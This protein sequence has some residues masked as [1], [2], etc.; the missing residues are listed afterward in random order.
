MIGTTVPTVIASGDTQYNRQ[1][2]Q[3]LQ[4][5]VLQFREFREIT[6]FDE[7]GALIASSRVG[8]PRITIPKDTSM[9]IDGV[10]MSPFTLSSNCC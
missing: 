4:N 5:Y 6:L 9:A 2:D 7:A 3:I 1:Q 10:V 8:K